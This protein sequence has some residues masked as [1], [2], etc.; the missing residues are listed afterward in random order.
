MRRICLAL[1]MLSWGAVGATHAAELQ[2]TLQWGQ[3][4]E[5]GTL[6]S[7]VVAEVAARPGQ[8][9]ARGEPLVRLDDRGFRAQVDGARAAVTRAQV[10]YEEAE[11]ERERA[12]ELYDRT[13]LS[14]HERQL[15]EIA[16]QEARADL[17]AARARLVQAELDLERS[18]LVAP[19]DAVVLQVRV[20]PG[21]VIVSDLQS[22]PLV[23]VAERGRLVARGLAP[24]ADLG[25]LEPG[26]EVEVEVRGD[27]YPGRVSHIG[28]EPAAEAAGRRVYPVEVSVQ[29]PADKRLYVG[30]AATIR[31]DEGGGA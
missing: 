4:A 31:W 1:A 2:A 25:A 28:L 23:V 30:E 29:I 8:R 19:Y 26:A 12:L 3:R 6:V 16:Y 20:G 22:E 13:V 7:G 21:Q 27:R 17:Q 10:R 24:V 14:E 9:V 15:A 11:R 18:R 5:L